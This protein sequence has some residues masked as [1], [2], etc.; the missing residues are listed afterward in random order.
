MRRCSSSSRSLTDGFGET[1][2]WTTTRPPRWQT[3]DWQ[4]FVET[5][6]FLYDVGGFSVSA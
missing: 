2:S 3:G 4:V 1:M 5:A 6:A